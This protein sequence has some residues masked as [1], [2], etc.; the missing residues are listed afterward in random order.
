MSPIQK[1]ALEI[2]SGLTSCIAENLTEET[3]LCLVI[4]AI[5]AEA[6]RCYSS[7][8]SELGVEIVWGA[9]GGQ[10]KRIQELESKGIPY[11]R[12]PE[13]EYSFEKD[14][15]ILREEILTKLT[16]LFTK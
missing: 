2:R 9:G 1:T 13:K 8:S 10:N 4:K 3:I 6:A 15:E 16:T 5:R 11:I 14:E 7:I 12:I